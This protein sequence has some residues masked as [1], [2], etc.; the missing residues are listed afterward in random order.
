MLETAG[1]ATVPPPRV[2]RFVAAGA[3][4]V[5]SCLTPPAPAQVWGGDVSWSA[6]VTRRSIDAYAVITGMDADQK[7]TANALREGYRAAF[8]TLQTDSEKA[9]RTLEL[10][11]QE[12]D[13]ERIYREEMPKLT[14]DFESRMRRLESEFFSDMK[15]ILN[16]RQAAQW[17]RVERARRRELGM[18]WGWL[19]GQ[20]VDVTS[21]LIS[22]GISLEHSPALRDEI[23]RYELDVDK[24]LLG[25]ERLTRE[26][27]EARVSG[28]VTDEKA[29]AAMATRHNELARTLRDLNR[30]SARAVTSLLPPEHAPKFEAEFRKR[31]FPRIYRPSYTTRVLAAAQAL[32]DLGDDQRKGVAALRETYEREAEAA[33]GR[34]AAAITTL[35]QEQGNQFWGWHGGDGDDPIG[36]ARKAR[37]ELDGRIR[38]RLMAILREDQRARMPEYVPEP[39]NDQWTGGPDPDDEEPPR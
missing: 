9:W 21:L 17:P 32:D 2:A 19:S 39:E 37:L 23:N 12:G 22:I 26:Q 35:E 20:T 6:P 38:E 4:F 10:R 13:P 34:W 11:A 36:L 3:L 16:D 15:L 29:Y 24:V 27:Q 8:K 1:R 33:N 31:C 5:L 18:R 28:A 25:I 14:R 30:A 7:A